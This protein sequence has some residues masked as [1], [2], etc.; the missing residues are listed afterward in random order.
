M[1]KYS[2][3][4]V[5]RYALWKIHDGK[6][7]WCGEPIRY[8]D[9]TI[10]HVIPES[11][12]DKPDEL[13]RIKTLY[14]LS[15]EFQV[16]DYC[17]WVPCHGTCNSS[18]QDHVFKGSP[19]IVII[20]E[21]IGRRAAAAARIEE[22][23]INEKRI[24]SIVGKL[25]ALVEKEAISRAELIELF[26]DSKEVEERLLSQIDQ[27][28]KR[29]SDN[30]TVVGLNN[31]IATVTDGK[32]I[33]RTPIAKDVHYSWECPFCKSYGPWSGILCLSCGKRSHE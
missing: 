12:D 26:S 14:G 19:V 33:G 28:I 17:N 2:F 29:V 16:N 8:R 25:D 21:G 5:Q 31:D 4:R 7:F 22:R 6:C 1:A 23:I 27:H 30:W 32:F 10:D 9:V 20:L 18:K 24:D 13:M 15:S 3:S 11:L